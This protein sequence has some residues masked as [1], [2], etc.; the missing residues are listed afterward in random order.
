VDHADGFHGVG[1]IGLERFLQ[2]GEVGALAP[3]ALDGLHVE[4]E[5]LHEADPDDGE[6]AHERHQDLVARRE[7]VRQRT[8]PCPCPC[9]ITKSTTPSSQCA[10]LIS[11]LNL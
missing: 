2:G 1:A 5:A 3:L 6:H 4:V 11:C 8:L 10:A 9:T 7:R